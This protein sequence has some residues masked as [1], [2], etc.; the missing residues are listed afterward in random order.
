[1]PRLVPI[2]L[3]VFGASSAVA[4]ALTIGTPPPQN[5]LPADLPFRPAVTSGDFIYLA[6][7]IST[8]DRNQFV[9][10][11]VRA[12]TTRVLENLRKTLEQAGGSI[13]HVASVQVYLKRA[14]DFQAM[15]EVYRACW[16]DRPPA[17]TTVVAGLVLPD[18]LVEMSLVGLRTGAERTVIHP[19][20][21]NTSP[22]PYSYAIKSGNT[23]FTSGLLA[24]NPQDNSP[25]A[26]DITVQTKALLENA[27]AILHASGM[28]YADV[29]SARVYL[30]DTAAFQDMNAA[31]RPFF[32]Q[33][34][35][36]RATVKAALTGA[37]YLVE[38]ALTAVKAT[39]RT[40]VT[41]P[42]A[43]GTP[44]RPSPVLSSAIRVGN[45]LY[46]SGM[47]G[48]SEAARGDAGAQAREALARIGRTLEAAGF[49]WK[50]VVD[51]VVFLPDMQHF[52]TMNDA[53]RSVVPQPF[54][55]RATVG[56]GLMAAD[57]L[58]E[59]IFVAA[60]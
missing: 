17:R 51:G 27:G 35:P 57:G 52:S 56:T 29:V 40:A 37:P 44:G 19:A 59:I 9:G 8:D 33:D 30:T 55:A 18:A 14:D 4:F 45:R 53:Y 7:R 2:V 54:P 20:G 58:I 60:K 15:N 23:L 43:D 13:E 32:P 47:L 41:T 11:D 10:G 36:A 46:L 12:Q 34:P 1:M 16:P 22:N 5:S 3:A 38:I 25:I 31:Y 49:G 24:R 50:N 6:G 42:N 39:D 48:N 26:G 28:T 21:W